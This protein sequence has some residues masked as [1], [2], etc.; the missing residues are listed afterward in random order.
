MRVF[1][2]A[3]LA[4]LATATLGSC[5]EPIA[6][7]DFMKKAARFS[8]YEVAAGKIA[9]EKGQS[10]PVKQFGRDVVEDHSKA[11][12]EFKRIVQAGN[13]KAEMPTKPNKNQRESI[14]A[15]NAATPENF[16]KTFADQQ[17]KALERAVEIFEGYAE[18][19]DDAALKQFAAN[20]LPTIKQHLEQAKKLSQ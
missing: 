20:T 1:I 15:L 2:L 4:T 16:D 11:G 18:G 3:A 6:T 10:E 12:A 9:I 14:G 5:A 7:P 17:I 8:L 13:I 19:G